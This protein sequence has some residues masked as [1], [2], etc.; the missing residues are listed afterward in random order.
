[1]NVLTRLGCNRHV[2]RFLQ[3]SRKKVLALVQELVKLNLPNLRLCITSRPEVDI[4]NVLDPL[5]STSSRVSLHDED[6]QKKDIADYIKFV[7]YSDKWIMKWPENDKEL[8][9]D[10]LSN[11][12]NGMYEAALR[13]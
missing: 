1:M 6:G 12:A 5:T 2:K 13:S 3:S 11:G 9:V 8:V 10:T 4:R 7:I